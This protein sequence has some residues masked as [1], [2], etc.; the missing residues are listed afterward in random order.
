MTREGLID[1]RTR[2]T[3]ISKTW[4]RKKELETISVTYEIETRTVINERVI[5]KKWIREQFSTL[6]GQQ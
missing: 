1:T 5:L 2:T 4:I 6:E 3:V